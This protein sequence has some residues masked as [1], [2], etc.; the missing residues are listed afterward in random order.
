[1]K[2]KRN[3]FVQRIARMIEAGGSSRGQ[4]YPEDTTTAPVDLAETAAALL[5]LLAKSTAAKVYLNVS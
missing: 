5:E 2:R 3:E 4:K 1:M